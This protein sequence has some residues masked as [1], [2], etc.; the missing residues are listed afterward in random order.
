VNL[1]T[2]CLARLL[3]F[4]RASRFVERGAVMTDLDGTAVHEIEGK[5][6]LS[7]TM[8]DGLAAVHARGHEV[9]I[10]TL[11]FPRSVISVIGDEWRRHTRADMPLVS[12]KGSQI[13]H[14]V[15]TPAG[16]LG[17]EELD[18]FPLNEAEILELMVGVRGMVD[19]GA[20][21]L[22]VFFYP[23]DW[24][25]GEQ[26]WTPREERIGHLRGKYLSAARVFSAGVQQLQ[27]ELLAQPQC[28]VFLLIDAPQD[29]LMA[30]QHTERARFVTHA[31][32]D[33]RHGAEA[34]ARALDVNL[35]DSIGA[36]DAETDTFLK[37]TGLAVIVGNGSID[38]K[39]VVETLRVPDPATFGE[40]LLAIAD[41]LP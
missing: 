2:N 33:K 4:M 16:A 28:M 32:V 23:R 27:D 37:A 19:Q 38:Y 41:A 25:Q 12:L 15:A 11:R 31:G 13:G 6:L 18:A 30:Y 35:A 10:N 14:V 21:D 26:I 8:Q 17:F 40:M 34:L 29:R 36:G 22:I 9:L 7:Q 39:G 5:V 24:R 20:D 1:D 3:H